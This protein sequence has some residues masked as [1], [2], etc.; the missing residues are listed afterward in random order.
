M[1][2][3]SNATAG[4]FA[5]FFSSFTLCP[6]ELVKCRLQALQEVAKLKGT[7]EN[8]SNI[9]PWKIT[10]EILKTDGVTGLFRGLVPTFFREMPGYFFFF[11]GYEVCRHMLTPP[12]KTKDE[13]GNYLYTNLK[14]C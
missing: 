4:F 13:I 6:T 1:H 3:I 14:S 9:G 5:A 10:R 8:V 12:G 7:T 2:P 11:G